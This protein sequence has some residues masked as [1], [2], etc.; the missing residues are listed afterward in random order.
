MFKWL[1]IA[2]A[3][4]II[5][6]MFRNDIKAKMEAGK[7][8]EAGREADSDM[9]KDPICGTF[10]NMADAITVRDGGKRYYFCGYDCRDAFLK[11]MQNG[12]TPEG[13]AETAR[14]TSAEDPAAT[15]EAASDTRPSNDSP[16]DKFHI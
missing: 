15:S 12:E 1:L 9:A 16:K 10:V 2:A 7:Q 4:Y 13:I 8:P 3:G 5:Y 14:A 11:R 6:L